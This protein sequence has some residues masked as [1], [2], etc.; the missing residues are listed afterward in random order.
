M[1]WIFLLFLVTLCLVGQNTAITVTKTRHETFGLW[2]FLLKKV[3]LEDSQLVIVGQHC[4]D[5]I[6]DNLAHFRLFPSS[7]GLGWLYSSYMHLF[8]KILILS[9]PSQLNLQLSPQQQV[10]GDNLTLLFGNK[11]LSILPNPCYILWPQWRNFDCMSQSQLLEIVLASLKR[12]CATLRV[13]P[14]PL[15]QI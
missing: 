2:D 1:L 15:H 10:M 6:C 14:A 8:V 13:W 3:A 7:L 4:T 11:I 9:L 12:L 5:V